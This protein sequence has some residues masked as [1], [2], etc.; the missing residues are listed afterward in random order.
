MQKNRFSF[1]F[2]PE[3]T[4]DVLF[5]V[6]GVTVTTEGN[7]GVVEDGLSKITFKVSRKVNKITDVI[8]FARLTT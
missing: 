1:L 4:D 2:I 7:L 8:K 3:G 5:A 6:S